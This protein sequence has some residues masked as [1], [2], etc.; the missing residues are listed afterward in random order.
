MTILYQCIWQTSNYVEMY[1]ISKLVF[2]FPHQYTKEK[3][4][5]RMNKSWTISLLLP[6]EKLWW[7]WFSCD[8]N[9]F[10]STSKSKGFCCLNINS[11]WLYVS[12]DCLT[13]SNQ[14]HIFRRE[15]RLDKRQPSLCIFCSKRYTAYSFWQ[16]WLMWRG[17][18]RENLSCHS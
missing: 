18:V 6:A 12:S 9:V 13:A 17:R 11:G 16:L 15:T 2:S 8:D 10:H 14:A 5:R 1:R 3:A 7:M 4:K